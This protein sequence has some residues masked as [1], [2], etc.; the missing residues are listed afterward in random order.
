MKQVD[1]GVRLLYLVPENAEEVIAQNRWFCRKNT[2][3]N[4]TEEDIRRSVNS[5]LS[6]A[7]IGLLEHCI[8]SVEIDLSR[9]A[10][11]QIVRHR[12]SSFVQESQRSSV[13]DP[14]VILPEMSPENLERSLTLLDSAYALYQDLLDS[15][16]RY[17]DARYI[18]PQCFTTRV[19][20]TANFRTWIHFLRL[21]LHPSAQ[22]EIRGLARQIQSLFAERCPLVFSPDAIQGYREVP[23]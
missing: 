1:P 5:A 18:L 14:E 15:G 7:H 19:R 23:E 22:A 9:V 4:P 11:H 13:Q 16:M 20:M 12:L 3:E 21:R 8:A 10:S 17:E 2:R 6:T